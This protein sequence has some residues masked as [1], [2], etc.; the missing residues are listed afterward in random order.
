MKPV[1]GTSKVRANA[2][3]PSTALS[4]NKHIGSSVATTNSVPIL[5]DDSDT[6]SVPSESSGHPSAQPS[7]RLSGNRSKSKKIAKVSNSKAAEESD[8]TSS[9]VH[10]GGGLSGASAK[11]AVTSAT[12]SVAKAGSTSRKQPLP[13]PEDT[14]LPSIAILNSLTDS[15]LPDSSGDPLSAEILAAIAAADAEQ[16][17][18]EVE[19]TVVASSA[20]TSKKRRGR[21][22]PMHTSGSSGSGGK[23]VVSPSSSSAGNTSANAASAVTSSLAAFSVSSRSNNIGGNSRMHTTAISLN[24]PANN[25]ISSNGAPSS[26]SNRPPHSRY[27]VIDD[28]VEKTEQMLRKSHPVGEVPTTTL[29]VAAA[30]AVAAAAS[31]T[32]H[33]VNAIPRNG[34]DRTG[35]IPPTL[36]SSEDG[37]H[38]PKT[39]RKQIGGDSAFQSGGSVTT[40]VDSAASRQ[41][42]IPSTLASTFTTPGGFGTI[43][44]P[45]STSSTNL[46]RP[47]VS[48]GTETVPSTS[49]KSSSKVKGKASNSKGY[50]GNPSGI[51]GGAS[52]PVA[53]VPASRVS[54][55]PLDGFVPS[56]LPTPVPLV[57]ARSPVPASVSPFAGSS[58]RTLSAP[59][60]TLVAPPPLAKA[61]NASTLFTALSSLSTSLASPIAQKRTQ[62][63]VS[64]SQPTAIPT[65]VSLTTIN[66]APSSLASVAGTG[67]TSLSSSLNPVSSTSL[68]SSHISMTMQDSSSNSFPP[69]LGFPS[70][71][72]ASSVQPLLYKDNEESLLPPIGL[73]AVLNSPTPV[74]S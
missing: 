8:L 52:V 11:A 3:P 71:P 9:G 23:E 30:A 50:G 63:S 35:D 27:P 31:A 49:L 62:E 2:T 73:D 34:I 60:Q 57:S 55:F 36:M 46:G 16:Q 14:K 12:S 56:P 6:S 54:T 18:E 44:H 67:M 61:P 45:S 64:V 53:P 32:L 59:T 7:P 51:G 69:G 40:A 74:R 20:R 15:S 42:I 29:G 47:A 72:F 43:Q 26:S 65:S 70:S 1:S 25:G 13:S 28:S 38:S 24:D 37:W 21:D 66:Y 68:S 48:S 4:E 33:G 5:V 39:K 58:S 41:R 10:Y 22:Q 19:F 17:E